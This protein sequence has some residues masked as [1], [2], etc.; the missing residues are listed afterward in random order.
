MNNVLQDLSPSAVS[1]AL[2]TNQIA[3][4][5]LLFSHF[6]EAEL[7]DDPGIFW[8]E[9]GIRHDVFNRVIQ[10][11]LELDTLP[12]AIERVL[13]YFQ[14]RR[15]PFL[16]HLGASSHPTNSGSILEGYGLTHYE[17]EPGMA[18]DLLRFN[19]NILVAP[20]LAIHPVTTDELIEQWIHVWEFG[21]PE[22][23]IHQWFTFYSGLCL[24]RE[25]PLHLYLGTLD[26]KPVATSEV[27]FGGGVASIG[28]VGT[29]PQHR[30]QG[31]GA[32][33]TLTALREAHRQG[34]RIGV[35]TASPMGINI[36]RRIGFQEY[37]TFST[38]LW[39][40]RY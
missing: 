9:T 35:L 31:I 2:D 34:Y 30:H 37:G 3:F 1:L 33:M 5:S 16:W 20:Q 36:Y 10:T 7:H 39:H 15:M 12:V 17:T 14:Q 8:F 25:S 27:F 28:S 19:E 22:E 23:V 24:N 26:G 38:Y 6:P 11:S 18:V 40:P 13:C 21:S 4:W 32:A 29:L